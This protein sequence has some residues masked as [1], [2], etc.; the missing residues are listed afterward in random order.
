M[1]FVKF[2]EHIDFVKEVTDAQH[3]ANATGKEVSFVW[4][5]YKSTV[6]PNKPDL[7]SKDLQLRLF[8][9]L[10]AVD[11][12]SEEEQQVKQV[13]SPTPRKCL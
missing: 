7:C 8:Y 1:N 6:E 11:D 3:E 2:P 4:R 9:A 5:G 13:K 12:L 10:K